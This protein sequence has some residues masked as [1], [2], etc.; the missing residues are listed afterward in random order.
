MRASI[1]LRLRTHQIRKL[2]Q[3]YQEYYLHNNNNSKH[4][5]MVETLTPRER[6][7]LQLVV[8]GRTTKEIAA[9]LGISF[10]TA[11]THRY[12]A[13]SKM[14]SANA[15]ALVRDSIRLGVVRDGE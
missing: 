7:V 13:M 10:K 14:G 1:A 9:E 12:S 3:E 2:I 4:T 8:R 15:A 6:D 11:A 5:A